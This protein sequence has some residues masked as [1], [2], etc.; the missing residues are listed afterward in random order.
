MSAE[1]LDGPHHQIVRSEMTT[2]LFQ[3]LL[4]TDFDGDPVEDPEDVIDAPL[5][6]DGA[7]R[8]VCPPSHKCSET[9]AYR[10]TSDSLLASR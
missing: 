3:S 9:T 4:M 7:T 8:C 2:C 6:G 10:R 5:D 1:Y